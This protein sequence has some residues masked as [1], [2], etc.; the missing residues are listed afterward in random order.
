MN[1]SKQDWQALGV[2]ASYLTAAFVAAVAIL[3]GLMG[4]IYATAHAVRWLG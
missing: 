4:V 3:G 2:M 1:T